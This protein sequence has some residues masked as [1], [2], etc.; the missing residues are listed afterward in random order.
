MVERRHCQQAAS[1]DARVCP[2]LRLGKGA[3][4]Q[5]HR[6]D[7]VAGHTQMRRVIDLRDVAQ[8]Q[9]I[10]A[11]GQAAW[12]SSKGCMC[13]VDSGNCNARPLGV[14]KS[15]SRSDELKRRVTT[16]TPVRSPMEQVK[17]PSQRRFQLTAVERMRQVRLHATPEFCRRFRIA[18]V[19]GLPELRG[20][21]LPAKR[22]YGFAP[23][24]V[25][26][27]LSSCATGVLL[28]GVGGT[29]HVCADLV[30]PSADVRRLPACQTRAP[31]AANVL[32][33][34]WHRRG[35][36]RVLSPER[37][38]R[39]RYP[40]PHIGV[41]WS[42][43]TT[44]SKNTRCPCGSGEKYRKCC[45]LKLPPPGLIE[46]ARRMFAAREKREREFI[47]QHGYARPPM[48]VK[49]FGNKMMVAIGG[50]LYQQTREGD[51]TFLHAI[52]DHALHF[53]GVPM[54]EAEE[55][56]PID[57]RHPALQWMNAYVH[58][59]NKLH[60]EGN[61]DP[62][63][64]QIGAGAAWYRFAYDLYTIQDNAKLE[65]VLKKRLLNPDSFQGA[66]HELWVAALSVAAGFE[67][68][69]EDETDNSKTHPEFV[70]TDK[71]SS[72]RIAV[73]AK[74]RRR[75]GAYGFAGGKDVPP[76][77]SVDIRQLVLDAY[78]KKTGLPFYIFIDVN[79]P[80]APDEATYERWIL[81][82]DKTMW[83]LEQEGY[84]TPATENVIFFS[85]DPSHYLRDEQIG[86]DSDRLWLKHYLSNEP[87][88]PHPDPD[89]LER[90]K[91]SHSQRLAPPRDFPILDQ[92]DA[93]CAK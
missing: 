91:K 23:R 12:R 90:F 8:A 46:Q 72:T 85:N 69:F 55:A 68:Q 14:T 83:D 44:P 31:Q 40:A 73:E 75:K 76:G 20:L 38:A 5:G 82:I 45:R 58:H 35:R 61:T 16:A 30:R 79:L 4:A 33:Q 63:A 17:E 64:S 80:P 67:L 50:S 86:N 11:A 52:H 43:S 34:A 10:I 32:P 1:N 48:A 89:V 27:Q 26:R 7:H 51:Y 39:C 21:P 18:F 60:A 87:R 65:A 57:E 19:Y 77:E 6:G 78:K 29:V 93:G 71:F 37:T 24:A 81:E 15:D 59:S 25:S 28:L 54:L 62:R 53:F 74:S 56:K 42:M 13:T 9:E 92:P 70:G 22:P 3:S 47:E 36:D 2:A 84:G 41:S 88:V 49:A 66:R